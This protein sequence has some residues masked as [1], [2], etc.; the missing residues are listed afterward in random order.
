ML[1]L[2]GEGN[3][4][5]ESGPVLITWECSVSGDYHDYLLHAF[6]LPVKG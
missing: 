3:I 6:L 4:W 1:W 2:L 5:N